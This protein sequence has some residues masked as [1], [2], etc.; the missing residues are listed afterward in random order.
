MMPSV[1]YWK[2][3]RIQPRR[4]WFEG[5]VA[6]VKGQGLCYNLDYGTAAD[7][8]ESRG[9]FVELPNQTNNRAFAGVAANSYNAVSGGQMIEIF[10]PGSICEL[11]ASVNTT[12]NSTILTCSAGEGDAGRF[13]QPG[14]IGRGSAI[15]LRTKTNII[16]SSYDGSAA[17]ATVTVTKTG[18]FAGAVAGDKVYILGG[19]SSAGADTVVPGEYTIASVTSND[20]VVLTAS[21]GTGQIAAYCVSGNPTV[22]AYLCDGEESGLQEV[23]S[24]IV[25]AAV[26]SM[27]GGK[28]YVCGGYTMGAADSTFALAAGD[29]I[30]MRKEFYGL[31]TLTTKGYKVSPAGGGIQKDRSSALATVLI[32][33]ADEVITLTWLDS[34]WVAEWNAGAT[35]A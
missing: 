26:A 22:L 30:G 33:A 25:S 20:E 18:M 1:N 15:A 12:I 27:V 7:H 4:V 8:D 5:N 21:A 29:R 31:G 32:D 34:K 16:G 10:E 28:T 13:G 14:F 23:I 9:N 11:A 6:L 35:I 24:P 19:A 17:V 3:A 2:Q